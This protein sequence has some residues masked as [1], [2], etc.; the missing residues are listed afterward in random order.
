MTPGSLWAFSQCYFSPSGYVPLGVGAFY[1]VA[2]PVS[3]SVYSCISNEVVTVGLLEV[4]KA[5]YWLMLGAGI[6]H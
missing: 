6:Y 1:W 4:G 3:S 2:C 5:L